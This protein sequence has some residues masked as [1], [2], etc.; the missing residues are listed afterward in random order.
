MSRKPTEIQPERIGPLATLPVFYRLAGRKVV[1]AGS[2]DGALWKAELLAA[3][4]AQLA[5]FAPENAEAFAALADRLAVRVHEGYGPI[6]V[7]S[8]AWTPSDL[9]GATIALGDFETDADAEKF[10]AAAKAAGAA[11]NIVDKPGFCDFQFGS[12]VNRSPLIVSIS[13]DGAAPV[14]GQAI[15]ARIESV[16]PRGLQAWAKAAHAWRPA[17]QA[18]NLAYAARRKVWEVFTALALK[19]FARAPGEADRAEM[20]ASLDVAQGEQRGHISLVGAGP[21]DASLLTLKAVQAMQAA[22]VILHDD[23]VSEEVLDLARR[24]ASRIRVGKK[25]HG[26][27]CKQSEINDLIVKL[28]LEGKRVVRLKGGDPLVFGRAT[29]ELI[30]ARAAGIATTIV[31][32]IS[33]AQAAAASLGVSLTERK[34]ARRIQFVTGHDTD[35]KLPDI[36]WRAVADDHASTAIYM[37]RKSLG[38]LSTTLIG[39]GLAGETPAVAVLNVSRPDERHIV[40]TLAGIE[41]DVAGAEDAPMIVLLGQAFRDVEGI[42]PR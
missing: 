42:A 40:S 29:E 35:G 13:T 18:L 27:S 3:T 26:P 5:V 16:L 20:M 34:I 17:V 28:A 22:D 41:A 12:I 8:R 21:G 6:T 33:T 2:S 7:I 1:L 30:A 15:R 25:G 39:L 4:G 23:L 38:T 14:F 10:V 19:D 31:P 24:E 32:G 37:P 36:D 9:T 11:V